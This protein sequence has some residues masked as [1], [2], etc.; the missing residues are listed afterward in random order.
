MSKTRGSLV[1]LTVAAMALML[2]ALAAVLAV[3]GLVGPVDQMMTE[4]KVLAA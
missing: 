1:L 4:S 2:L 3:D